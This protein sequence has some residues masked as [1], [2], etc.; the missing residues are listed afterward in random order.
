MITTKLSLVALSNFMFTYTILFLQGMIFNMKD[1]RVQVV[2][3]P[4]PEVED[5][6]D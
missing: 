1:C 6:E 5:G 4:E 2:Q 3:G